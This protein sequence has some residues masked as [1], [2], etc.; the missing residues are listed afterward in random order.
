VAI[1][2]HCE[3]LAP[4]QIRPEPAARDASGLLPGWW[5]GRNVT[6]SL[7]Q[8]G[9][10]AADLE[11]IA[12]GT[13][14][15]LA[16]WL[17]L[18]VLTRAGPQPGARIFGLITACLVAWSVAI[19]IQ[20]LTREPG[21][22]SGPLLAIE[23]GTAYLL[24]AAVLHITLVLTVET[25]RSRLQ[26]AFLVTA[27]AVCGTAALLVMLFPQWRL[28]VAPPHLELPGITG[29]LLGWV[30]IAVRIAILAAALFWSGRALL[31]A[32]T[33]STRR[34]QLGV[35]LATVGVAAIGAALG[36]LPVPAAAVPWL[37]VSVLG[38][39]VLLAAYGVFAQGV[40]L[41]PQVAAYAFRYTIV[42]GLGVIVYVVALMGFDHLAQEVLAIDV[43]I[44]ASLTLVIT[45]ALF[46]PIAGWARRKVRGRSAR[47][48]AYDRLLRALGRDVLTAQRPEAVVIPAL[49]RLSGTFR[50]LGAHV[51]TSSGDVIARHGKPVASSP[52]ALRM[53]LIDSNGSS[54]QVVYGPK[55][56]LLPFTREEVDLLSQGAAYLSASLRLAELHDV[57][58]EALEALTAEHVAVEARGTGLR[59]AL[60]QAQQDD[61]GLQ[62]FA[63][64]PLRVERNGAPVQSWGGAK[65]GT[66][67][68]EALF[69]FLFDRGE[70]GVAKD[71]V[72]ELIWPDVDLRRADLAF[73]RTLSGLRTTLEP[74]RRG[75]TKG[76]A[77]VFHNDR[78][79]L[80]PSV[81]TWSDVRAF[82]EAMAASAAAVE[83]EV[84]QHLEHARALYRGD[85]LDDCPFY[86]DSFQAEELRAVLRGR[87]VDLL[88][89]LG[90]TY[91]RRGDRPS[92][93]ASFRQAQSVAG[94]DLPRADAALSRL[95]APV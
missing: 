55:R 6:A 2:R 19:L 4:S 74:G 9:I 87:F 60:A 63:L 82:D 91:E 79:R 93:A 20:R 33:D 24:P 53:P 71:E 80:S 27:Y 43:P 62:V 69:A 3:S 85:Y 61:H 22:F 8:R 14:A 28:A 67:H 84:I 49:A 7:S 42:I 52:L 92:A 26:Q 47:E 46:D 11:L 94:E 18:I 73:H 54:G 29:E 90:E 12:H 88:L 37:S 25:R 65:A 51:E 10:V 23:N 34:R 39:A 83:D 75:L 70:R 77:I 58:S 44:V 68:A 89:A 35:T 30:W 15:I 40:F 16:T 76:E 48:T 50:L 72:T 86:G 57:Q 81:V 17:G 78:Y 31:G 1:W 38:I 32:R 36:I 13:T 66:R 21:A 45:I 56:S 64:G 41:T 95:A 5:T 59:H